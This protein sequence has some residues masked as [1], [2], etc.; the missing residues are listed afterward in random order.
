MTNITDIAFLDFLASKGVAPDEYGGFDGATK[1][2]FI[3]A[4]EKHQQPPVQSGNYLHP[5]MKFISFLSYIIIIIIILSLSLLFL[6]LMQ[7]TA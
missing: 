6:L 5:V 7:N 2:G 1:L 4:F 3:Q